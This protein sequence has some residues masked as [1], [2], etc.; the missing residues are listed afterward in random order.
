MTT[1]PKRPTSV[2]EQ[3]AVSRNLGALARYAGFLVVVI[4]LF[5]GIF[6]TIMSQIEGQSHSWV[7]AIY[8]TLVTMST[9]GFGDIVFL[10]DTGRIFTLVVLLS[11]TVLL[12]VVLPFKLETTEILVS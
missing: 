9:L 12:L 10:S 5:S 2:F 7:T 6:Q 4:L 8:W 11:G 3:V 1:T